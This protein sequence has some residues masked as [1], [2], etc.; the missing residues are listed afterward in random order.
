[1]NP[2]HRAW[3][4]IS[5]KRMR[6]LILFLILTLLLTSM[7]ICLTILDQNHLL[8]KQLVHSLNTS[9][10]I[11][12][13]EKGVTFPLDEVKNIRSIKGISQLAPEL[14]TNVTLLNHQVVAGQQYI[15]REDLDIANQQLLNLKALNDSDKD[16]I[17]RSTAFTLIAGRH[18]NKDDRHKILIHQEL[19][20]KNGLTLH[21]TLKLVSSQTN[22]ATNKPINYEIIGIFTG[23]KEEE[24]TG[25]SSDF[26]ENTVFSDYNSSQ[27]LLGEQ[28]PLITSA[29]FYL[30]HPEQMSSIL[31]QVN[32]L[33]LSQQGFQVEKNDKEFTQIK[34]SLSASQSF[35]QLFLIG[36]IIT[37]GGTLLLVLSLWMRERVYEVGI[38]LS[39]GKSKT[40][41]LSQFSFEIV[42]LSLF[43][44][45][46]ALGIVNLSSPAILDT[47]F[48]KGQILFT[49]QQEGSFPS[50]LH[51]YC[52]LLILSALTLSLSF[53]IFFWKNPRSLLTT[54]R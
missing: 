31:E 11:K 46:L 29:H 6:S 47:V 45:P 33:N 35:L 44:L 27:K 32:Q 26:S 22:K 28:K 48:T 10:T 3:A 51:A 53:L 8:K 41:I 4:Y 38:L 2:I 42:L 21:D 40:N 5:R 15:Q 9:F 49:G 23:K 13:I 16:P 1:M 7:A 39:L 17:F 24:F 18:L 50:F 43:S 19:A 54:I 52:L 20:K 14:E 34:D 30:E 37:G 36:I 25:L 12:K